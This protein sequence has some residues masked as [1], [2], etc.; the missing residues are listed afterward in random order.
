MKFATKPYDSKFSNDLTLGMLLH[1]FF[2]NRLRFDEVKE[3]LKVGTFS[4]HSVC[5]S[6]ANSGTVSLLFSVLDLKYEI[7]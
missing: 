3:S 4:G 6:S 7:N 2:D 1:Y 5:F